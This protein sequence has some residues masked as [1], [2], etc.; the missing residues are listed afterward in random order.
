MRCWETNN[1]YNNGLYN[2]NKDTGIAIHTCLFIQAEPRR[3]ERLGFDK[4]QQFGGTS[5]SLSSQSF[6]TSLHLSAIPTE[7]SKL[8]N[9]A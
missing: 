6:L 8:P 9:V 7:F 4:K 3:T 5:K 1:S 2:P